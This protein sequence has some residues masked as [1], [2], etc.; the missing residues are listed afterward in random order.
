MNGAILNILGYGRETILP[1]ESTYRGASIAEKL[2]YL[3]AAIAD[4]KGSDT[5]QDAFASGTVYHMGDYC[6][7]G[8]QLYQCIV[9]SSSKSWVPSEWMTV[10][11]TSSI[12]SIQR[13][14]GSG[15][16]TIM[17]EHAVNP[18]KSV[19]LLDSGA[20]SG[21]GS[22]IVNGQYV[23]AA[24]AAS[25]GV[26]VSSLSSSNF[27]IAGAVVS[28]PYANTQYRSIS[29][30]GANIAYSWQVIEYY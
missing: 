6:I 12:K 13:G 19:V 22:G 29:M 28:V 3:E 10:T 4:L 15:N 27:T 20:V 17:L 2:N 5:Q 18:N 30:Q 25:D 7:Q 26:Y 14:T 16:G 21:Y 9:E 11:G 8:G 23:F 1:S 24:A